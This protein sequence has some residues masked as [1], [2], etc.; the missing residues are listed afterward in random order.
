MNTYEIR[1]EERN[2]V[3]HQSLYINDCMSYSIPCKS[4]QHLKEK[5][6]DKIQECEMLQFK[7]LTAQA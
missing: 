1:I 4:E 5:F 6:N 7:N 3:M 2:E